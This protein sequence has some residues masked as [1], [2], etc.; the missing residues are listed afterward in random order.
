MEPYRSEIVN[1]KT[2]LKKVFDGKG[3]ELALDFKPLDTRLA[4]D[5]KGRMMGLSMTDDEDLSHT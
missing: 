1:A 4:E 2:I 5:L 3:K